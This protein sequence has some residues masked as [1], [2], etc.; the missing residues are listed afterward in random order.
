MLSYRDL[1][2]LYECLDSVISQTYENIEL[3]ISNDGSDEFNE[4]AIRDY[5]NCKCFDNITSVIINKNEQNLGTVK[6]CNKAIDL[7]NGD[8]IMM[9]ACDD[10]YSNNNV[11]EDMIN[12]FSQVDS[13]VMAIVG[14]TAMYDEHLVFCHNLYV[15]KESQTLINSLEPYEL[16]RDY[17]VLDN[18]L[19]AASVAYKRDVFE[20]FGKF[21]EKYLLIEDWTAAKSYTKQGMRYHYLDIMCVYHRDGGVSRRAAALSDQVTRLFK[22]DLIMIYEDSLEEKNIK[23]YIRKLIKARYKQQKFAYETTFVAPALEAKSRLLYIAL[24]TMKYRFLDICLEE[25]SA[26][27]LYKILVFFVAVYFFNYTGLFIS[28]F[29]RDVTAVVLLAIIAMLAFSLV[30]QKVA[31]L[32]RRIIQRFER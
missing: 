23:P 14:Q 18:L 22:L 32:L 1:N 25:L 10:V 15:T 9:I 27:G 16:Y 21:D 17:L 30:A 8:Y 31:R 26:L 24:V 28:F 12:E 19:P 5:A 29:D 6:H 3:I 11:V 7:S 2:H 4:D 20:T 13:D